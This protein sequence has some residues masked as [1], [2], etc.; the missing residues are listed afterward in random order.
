MVVFMGPCRRALKSILVN[1]KYMGRR[2]SKDEKS[3]NCLRP[4]FFAH[5]KVMH[6][7]LVKN[8]E[9]SICSSQNK[10]QHKI[11][12]LPNNGNPKPI[13]RGFVLL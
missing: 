12:F 5:Q 7:I 11:V 9:M 3:L 2:H 1:N 13:P 10:S 6:T 4:S 8:M